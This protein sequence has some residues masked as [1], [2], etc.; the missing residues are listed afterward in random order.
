MRFKHYITEFYIELLIVLVLL[1]LA[2]GVYNPYWMPMG[3]QILLLTALLVLFGFFTVFLWREQ[4]GDE[5]ETALRHMSDRVG[6][7]SGASVL[8]IAILV[9][10][11]LSR[12]RNEWAVG[13]LI[14]M[15]TAKVLSFIYHNRKNTDL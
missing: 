1:A 10:G 4:G 12:T 7:F 8:L 6:F 5:R 13:A 9:D 15:I 14:V 2:V 11:V 3:V